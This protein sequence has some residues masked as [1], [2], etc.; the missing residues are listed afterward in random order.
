MNGYVCFWKGK[1]HEVYAET[2]LKA[3]EAAAKFFKARRQWEVT[4]MLAEVDG[5][6]VVHDGAELSGS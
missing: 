5:R 4:V 2:T 6:P 3:Q 1:R